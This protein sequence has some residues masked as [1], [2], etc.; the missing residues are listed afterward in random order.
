MT[1][2]YTAEVERDADGRFVLTFPDFGWGATDGCP[3]PHPPARED[4]WVVPGAESFERD[5]SW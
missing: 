4:H 1:R 3:P 5:S 2:S